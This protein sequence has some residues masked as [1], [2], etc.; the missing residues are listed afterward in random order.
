MSETKKQLQYIQE[1]LSE[2]I[3]GNF[4]GKPFIIDNIGND[5]ELIQVQEGI[6]TLLEKLNTTNGSNISLNSIY[7]GISD[8]LIVLD[9]KIQIQKTNH[10]VE[11]VLLYNESELLN[12]SIGKLIRK[13]DFDMVR[14]C[15]R[16]T[17]TQKKLIEIDLNLIAKNNRQVPVSWSFSPLF[18][19]KGESN[20]ILLVAKNISAQID[21]KNQL[22]D[23]NDELNLFVYKAS[24]DLKSPVSSM[25]SLMGLINESSTM[26]E[27]KEYC[28]LISECTSRLDIII[29]DLL[30]LGRITYG[31][32]EFKKVDIKDLID[33]I[34]KSIE[35]AD[36]VKDIDFN[37]SIDDKARSIITEKGLLQTVL[38]NLID[39]AVKYRENK[40]ERSFI[41]IH[42]DIHGEGILFK[43]EDNGIGI[44]DAQQGNV[45]K[46]FYRATSVSKGSGL[47]LY[48][49]KTSI[50]KLRG[51]IS[52]ESETGKGTTF[53]I[54]IP[55]NLIG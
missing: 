1:F 25:Q 3:P 7:N 2:I 9:D 28:K 52:F 5:E 13:S 51:T 42:T 16:N 11:E 39:N 18:N 54:Y 49:V 8:I 31:E 24:H 47:G 36:G 40:K 10:I 6:K 38:F 26:E 45:F 55:S 50:A 35:F 41:N 21:A 17:Y 30:V 12:Q 32:L 53:K 44:A 29:S 48:I 4:N 43:I 22:Q 19:A 46:M 23:K 27:M 33:S 20:G 37:I 15:I 14:D 34:L